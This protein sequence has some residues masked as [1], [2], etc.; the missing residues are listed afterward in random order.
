VTGKKLYQAEVN[1]LSNAAWGCKESIEGQFSPRVVP[2]GTSKNEFESSYLA[3]WGS[4]KPVLRFC[5]LVD[6]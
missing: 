3:V 1:I 4:R 6:Q 2:K 5:E